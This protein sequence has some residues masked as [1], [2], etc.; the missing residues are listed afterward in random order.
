MRG[1]NHGGLDTYNT[2]SKVFVCRTHNTSQ[3]LSIVNCPL[4]T[5]LVNWLMWPF[6]CQSA[7]R[8]NQSRY[9]QKLVNFRVLSNW[10][11]F[12]SPRHKTLG[13]V[14]PPSPGADA[15][16][17]YKPKF[18]SSKNIDGGESFGSLGV[19]PKQNNQQNKEAPAPYREEKRGRE[20]V[21]GL[22]YRG[23]FLDITKNSRR[24]SGKFRPF[25]TIL[26]CLK[27]DWLKVMNEENKSYLSALT[28]YRAV[29]WFLNILAMLL[30]L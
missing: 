27:A 2:T 21:C 13:S 28:V 12:K 26:S 24:P 22:C 15:T 19:N 16:T 11:I 14:Y 17:E 3:W 4:K 5:S 1:L 8:S 23:T 9:N 20:S 7:W 10:V 25:H 29:K 6:T 18:V 30:M